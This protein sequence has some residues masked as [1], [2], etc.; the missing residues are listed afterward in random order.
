M[1]INEL[2]GQPLDRLTATQRFFYERSREFTVK[3]DGSYLAD[4]ETFYAIS[5]GKNS[6][7][8]LK[9]TPRNTSEITVDI[10]VS[11]KEVTVW[12]D[13]WHEDIEFTDS[14]MK[15]QYEKIEK[16]VMFALSKQCK[17]IIYKAA[18]KAYKW[19]LYAFENGNWKFYSMAASLVYNFLGH[20]TTEEKQ[21]RVF[22]E[23]VYP[24]ELFAPKMGKRQGRFHL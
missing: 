9:L 21:S 5:D 3:L 16:L 19:K 22:N 24:A 15:E 14:L 6:I 10:Y 23:A 1:V 12:L 4:D 18:G 13:G 17:I 8:E 7:L 2:R 20:R 11:P